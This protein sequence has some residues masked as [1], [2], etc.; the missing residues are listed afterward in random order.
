MT[1]KQKT[2]TSNNKLRNNLK[3]TVPLL[4]LLS[5]FPPLTTDMILPALPSLAKSWN[6]SL[7]LINL[8]LVF[9]FVTY[10][11]FLLFY[12]PISDRFGRRRPLLVGLA[13]YIVASL[14][15]ASNLMF[16]ALNTF[17]Y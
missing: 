12:G 2:N 6:V 8:N 14:L 16:N 3:V 13:V 9:F 15:G 7:S 5:A 1:S 10:G 17:K 11:L 4:A